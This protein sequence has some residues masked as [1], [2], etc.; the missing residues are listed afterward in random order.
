VPFGFTVDSD[1]KLV[2]VKSEQA[3]IRRM[4]ALRAK[5]LS[6]RAISAALAKSGVQ[7]SHVSVRR[8]LNDTNDI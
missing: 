4:H 2:P 6:F 8:V 7:V 3:A 5:G 1:R